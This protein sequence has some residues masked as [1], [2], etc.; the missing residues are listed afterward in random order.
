M[1]HLLFV[2]LFSLLLLTR[3]QSGEVSKSL[4]YNDVSINPSSD[5]STNGP[6]DPV[7]I[8]PSS[9]NPP[10][11]TGVSGCDDLSSN[12]T[13]NC[14][15]PAVLIL[16]G[17][18]FMTGLEYHELPTF[19]MTVTLTS[20]SQTSFCWVSVEYAA[21]IT[22]SQIIC[23]VTDPGL[24]RTAAATFRS[25]TFQNKVTGNS[26]TLD[27]AVNFS[28]EANPRVSGVS[29]C[30]VISSD[31]RSASQCDLVNDRIT[32]HGTG[33]T[34]TAGYCTLTLGTL[35]RYFYLSTDHQ[36]VDY[37]DDNQIVFNFGASPYYIPAIEAQPGTSLVLQMADIYGAT[38]WSTEAVFVSFLP[39]PGPVIDTVST[40]IL[41]QGCDI[42]N[43]TSTPR[44]RDC[45]SGLSIL[46]VQGSFLFSPVTAFVGGQACHVTESS[47]SSI[48]IKMPVFQS[49]EGTFYDLIVST[50]AGSITLS[51]VIEFNHD[52]LIYDVVPCIDIGYY[53]DVVIGRCR[54]TEVV[55]FKVLNLNQTK[56]P[57]VLV[58]MA[59]DRSAPLIELLNV[60]VIDTETITCV[61]PEIPAGWLAVA[62]VY[63]FMQWQDGSRTADLVVTSLW[64]PPNAPRLSSLSG[65][66]SSS[67]DQLYLN[68]CLGETASGIILTLHGTGFAQPPEQW[69]V[70]IGQ[71]FECY[72][73]NVVSDETIICLLPNLDAAL[74]QLT[75]D[76]KYS[77][78]VQVLVNSQFMST[79]AGYITFVLQESH[80]LA[81]SS[82]SVST[83]ALA[84]VF[85]L[86]GAVLL[87]V[88][89]FITC[90]AVRKRKPR[91]TNEEHYVAS[92]D[93]NDIKHIE[94]AEV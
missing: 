25:I 55:T 8:N 81:L 41:T 5:P 93:S 80:P 20:N 43:S 88:C 42:D 30:P 37:V 32:L 17:S 58:G 40:S 71:N 28:D 19:Y 18:G 48:I 29:G 74:G 14:H 22:D 45:V 26:T 50:V 16:T 24:G 67:N 65:C 35:T 53:S 72:E 12:Q 34:F 76:L 2:L 91:N 57:R 79:N 66:F 10:I 73:P 86:V 3:A 39:L 85:S 92:S 27:N 62:T 36:L 75:F 21:N 46:L 89:M 6:L 33:F 56:A 64:D 78:I 87:A 31:G 7:I 82:V 83:I 11:L 69:S 9:G 51:A 44:Y 94:L 38:V 4:A 77:V 68:Q 70:T 90:R 63:V 49:L 23:F 54:P 1:R 15:V 60:Q 84:T 47:V 61:M 59:S 52:P 13:S